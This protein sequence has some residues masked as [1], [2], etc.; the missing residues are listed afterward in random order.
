MKK[1]ILLTGATGFLG[2]HILETLRENSEV[3]ILKRSFSDTGRIRDFLPGVVHYDADTTPLEHIF[4]ERSIDGIIHAAT[5]YG[6]HK[7]PD[8][9]VASNVV[10]PLKLLEL[11]I[12]HGI[13]FFITPIFYGERL[14]PEQYWWIFNINPL[15]QLILPFRLAI[16]EPGSPAFWQRSAY[17]L[18]F[19][20]VLVLI[21]RVYWRKVRNDIYFNV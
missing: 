6:R 19:A 2:S 17:S 20:V 16:M 3:I 1:R 15:Y 18:V 8:E 11:G 10:F 12:S 7:G 13:S 21:S 4:K 9:V 14:V 5:E